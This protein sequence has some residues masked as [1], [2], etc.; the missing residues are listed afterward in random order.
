M[1][2]AAEPV[3]PPLEALIVAAPADKGVSAPPAPTLT[4]FAGEEDQLAT[5]VKSLLVP[6]E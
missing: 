4:M 5:A 1:F 3:T 6:S 2:S